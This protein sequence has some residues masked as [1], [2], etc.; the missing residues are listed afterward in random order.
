VIVTCC[1]EIFGY[2]HWYKKAR[3][4]AEIDG[5]FITTPSYRHILLSM[6]GIVLMV[7]ALWLLTL[8]NRDMYFILVAVI[9]AFVFIFW[10]T[11]FVMKQMKRRKV[12]ATVSRIA[13]VAIG[14]IC[15]FLVM[16]GVA[17]GTIH[18][19]HTELF[20]EAPRYDTY[21]Y[22]GHEFHVYN[23][24]LPLYIEDLMATDYSEYSTYWE[25]RESFLL[26]KYEGFQ[27]PRVDALGEPSLRYDV[28]YV[29]WSALYD[30]CVNELVHK[31][32]DWYDED[33]PKEWRDTFRAVDS[34]SWNAKT[35]YQ[36]YTGDTPSEQYILCYDDIIVEL[37]PGFELTDAQK[38]IVSEK[39]SQQK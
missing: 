30:L 6:S 36:K 2:L 9:L 39:L 12:S 17:F 22:Q 19:L 20:A 27:R 1:I 23:D 37:T 5:T 31:Y 15:G 34:K 4:A 35:V 28:Y 24:E 8:H 38:L 10:F 3:Y 33:V 14:F 13:T 16:L 18:L 25:G 21:V 11:R 26:A 29:K 32:D 7:F